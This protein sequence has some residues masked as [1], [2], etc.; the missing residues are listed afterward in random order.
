[1]PPADDIGLARSHLEALCVRVE[2]AGGVNLEV[3]FEVGLRKLR[4]V[5][6]QRFRDIGAA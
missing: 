1:M 6:L 3:L 2:I 5:V 4:E